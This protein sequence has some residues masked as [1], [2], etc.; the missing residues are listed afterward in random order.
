MPV[1]GRMAKEGWIVPP[2]EGDKP[3]G[4]SKMCNPKEPDVKQAVIVASGCLL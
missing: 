1:P 4:V 2:A 3:S